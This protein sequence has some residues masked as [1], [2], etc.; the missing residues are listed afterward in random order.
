MIALKKI[1]VA[2]DSGR[3]RMRQ[4]GMGES[5]RAALAARCTCCT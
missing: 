3:S 5:W 2:T 1:L 4:C